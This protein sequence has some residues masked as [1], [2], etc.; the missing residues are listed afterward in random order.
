MKKVLLLLL[1]IYLVILCNCIAP[2][3]NVIEGIATIPVEHERL[4]LAPL[5]NDVSLESLESWPQE[6]AK[7]KILLKN[8]SDIW[9]KLKSEFIRC[10][11]F[12]LYKIVEDTEHPTVRISVTLISIEENSSLSIPVRLEVERLP[13]GHHSVYTVPAYAAAPVSKKDTNPF[14]YAN[15][16]FSNYRRNFPYIQIV[17]FFYPHSP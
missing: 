2:R 1:D 6:P 8:I 15:R 17:S 10:E 11:K 7:Q 9:K 12:G 3:R 13:D 16:L 5:K 4:Y 14:N